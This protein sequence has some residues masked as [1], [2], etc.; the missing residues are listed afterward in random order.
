MN[1]SKAAFSAV[2]WVLFAFL[3]IVVLYIVAQLVLVLQPAY[4]YETAIQY[5]MSDSIFCDGFVLLEETAVEGSGMLGYLVEDGE[6]VSAGES[7][8]EIYI[9]QS[10][11]SL[12]TQLNTILAE[13]SLLSD[14]QD[15]SGEQLNNLFSD[16]TNALYAMIKSV[17]QGDYADTQEAEQEYR[18][19]QN[20][21]QV[22]TGEQTDFADE[23][24]SLETQRDAL[25]T[26]LGTLEE[27]AAPL[28]GYFVS[29]DSAQFLSVSA[30][31]IADM[32][33][34]EFAAFASEKIQSDSTG[35]AGK[36][37]SNYTWYFVGVCTAEESTRFAVGDSLEIT[38]S[39]LSGVQLPAEVIS[40][41]VDEESG[42]ARVT[43]ECEYMSSAVLALG[44]ETAELILNTYEGLRVSKTALRM[45]KVESEAGD[46]YV[47]GVYVKYNNLAKFRKVEILYE[48]DDYILVP[49][50]PSS[51]TVSEIQ[52]YD[53]I[54]ISGL[55]LADGKLL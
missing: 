10:Q 2:R 24:L 48:T 7:V 12:R 23:I 17:D 1:K 15:T 32:T 53:Q 49:L 4:Q 42:V 27:I 46:E 45:Q 34:A 22:M 25:T 13:I 52:L 51:E 19:A 26:Q 36:I 9:A 20:K 33:V 8:A 43:V 16:R 35:Y 41:E 5:T 50:A 6:R 55:D 39:S 37:V 29:G 54:I 11:R 21:I 31:D 38:F 30:Q 40:L 18:L 47:Y 3:G 28:G 44:Q 14:S